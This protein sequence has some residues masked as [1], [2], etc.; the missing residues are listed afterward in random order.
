[1]SFGGVDI[2]GHVEWEAIVALGTLILALATVWLASST[3]GVAR[4]TAQEVAAQWR[5]VLLPGRRGQEGTGYADQ[6]LVY[7]AGTT[8]LSVS[9]RNAGRGPALFVRVLLDPDNASPADWNL[10]ALAPG[11]EEQLV[12]RGIDRF[13]GPK[14]LLLDY[15]DLAGK[16]FA[17]ALVL[18]PDGP[19]YYDVRLFEGRTLT[20]HG[21]AVPQSGLRPL[22]P[23]TD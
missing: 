3:R 4:A 2:S 15:R 23:I 16:Q 7:D 17:S 20:P 9:I 12:F 11:D 10:G 1:M 19:R 21:D 6:P 18:S 14:Q 5:P 22:P 13:D 8:W